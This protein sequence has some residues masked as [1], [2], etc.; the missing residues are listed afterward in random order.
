MA[1]PYPPLAWVQAYVPDAAAAY[2][3]PGP[4]RG[5]LVIGLVGPDSAPLGL[6]QY[7]GRRVEFRILESRPAPDPVYGPPVTLF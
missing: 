4:D 3:L 7:N 6:H 5:T 2:G 1:H